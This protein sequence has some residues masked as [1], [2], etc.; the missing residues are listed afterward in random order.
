MVKARSKKFDYTPA[1]FVALLGKRIKGFS[2]ESTEAQMRL[3]WMVWTSG[4]KSRKH[5]RHE[6]AIS[7]NYQEL[8][9][10]FGRGGFEAINERVKMFETTGQ[11][12]SDEGKTRAFW[13]SELVQALLTKYLDAEWK[14]AATLLLQSGK[15][16]R[17]V[18][19]LLESRD[20][21]GNNAKTKLQSTAGTSLVRVDM[22]R[23]AGLKAYL[24]EK[25]KDWSEG[26]RPSEDLFMVV[27]GPDVLNRLADDVGRV[28]RASNTGIGG[29]GRLIHQYVES[30]SGRLFAQNVNLQSAPKIVKQAALYGQWEYDFS[31]C[32]FSIIDQ[33]AARFGYECTAIRHYLEHKGPIRELIAKTA[34][35][36]KDDA[37]SALL[38]V[39]Y[40]A[41]TV[42][43]NYND[44]A[45][46]LGL[47]A[48]KRLFAVPEFMA[49]ADDV[50]QARD[51]ILASWPRTANG[52]IS[53]DYGKAIRPVDK[54]GKKVSEPRL[55]SHIITG[56]EAKALVTAIKL[57]PDEIVLYQHDGWVSTRKLDHKAIE[58]AVYEA[59][60]YELKLEWEQIY[61]DPA[62]PFAKAE[63]Q[64]NAKRK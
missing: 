1:D 10:Y 47:D 20:T 31:N 40:G 57:Y 28:M 30:G 6:D 39:M 50:K 19:P 35:I 29:Y 16:M 22:E 15:V 8:E 46:G 64:Q 32:H 23:L 27:P 53:N 12:W 56:V 2:E 49:I 61:I 3:A 18:P 7:F 24:R 25:A 5:S 17:T 60:G 44:I 55:L 13:L 38:A 42:V 59:T 21:N 62:A 26:R 45:A 52:S 48:A 34:E 54:N 4:A 36:H 9:S 41:K 58:Q 14:K 11:W 43:S 63:K 37:K 51:C 33:M